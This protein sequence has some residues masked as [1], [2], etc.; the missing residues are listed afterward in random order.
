MVATI[1]ALGFLDEGLMVVD[2]RYVAGEGYI[3][4]DKGILAFSAHVTQ[5]YLWVLGTYEI[6]RIFRAN[7]RL[8][9]VSKDDQLEG[10]YEIFT[11]LRIPLAKFEPAGK[12]RETDSH[13][14][15][16][17]LNSVYGVAWQVAEDT[18]IARGELSDRFL[19]Y[20]ESSPPIAHA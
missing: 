20:L 17:A 14:A 12:H 4:G 3:D 8:A 6:V 18:Y 1:Q 19:G 7:S 2:A 15:F 11:R 9:G 16:P 13:V 10:L 5:S